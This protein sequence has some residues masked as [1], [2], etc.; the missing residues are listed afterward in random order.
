MN[1]CLKLSEFPP[2]SEIN[3]WSGSH[4]TSATFRSVYLEMMLVSQ[5]V[6]GHMWCWLAPVQDILLSQSVS[7]KVTLT[8]LPCCGRR[9]M[10]VVHAWDGNWGTQ[11]IV[12][13]YLTDL[14]HKEFSVRIQYCNISTINMQLSKILKIPTAAMVPSDHLYNLIP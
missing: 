11:D 8:P 10:N 12:V 3:P 9:R 4:P 6:S 7:L 5:S 1:F 2:L 14:I 13:G